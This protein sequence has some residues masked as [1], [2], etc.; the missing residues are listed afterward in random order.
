MYLEC[1]FI[2]TSRAESEELPEALFFS[3]NNRT[4]IVDS[5]PKIQILC[6][7][8]NK[9]SRFDEVVDEIGKA[10]STISV[11]IHSL[12]EDGL[13][14]ERIDEEDARRKVLS[15]GAVFL[16]AVTKPSPVEPD[17][18]SSLPDLTLTSFDNPAIVFRVIFNSIRTGLIENGVNVE[19][20]MYSAGVSVGKYVA[21][22]VCDSSDDVFLDNLAVFFS[23]NEL[24]NVRVDQVSPFVLTVTDCYECQSLPKTGRPVCYFD[25]GLL[26][27]VFSIQKSD[28]YTAIETHCYSA[29]D[30]FCRFI[31]SKKDDPAS[32]TVRWTV[33]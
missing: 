18:N 2:M 12:I 21:K 11:Q 13:L 32:Q 24:G 5:P 23:G 17:T 33:I 10:K 29:G 20:I 19:P 28:G 26:S 9:E 14:V 15:L 22:L 8:L 4:I 31:V 30:D 25:A 1:P 7:I 6:I 3:K 27:E 16:G